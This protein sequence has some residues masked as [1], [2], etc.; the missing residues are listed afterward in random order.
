VLDMERVI[1]SVAYNLAFM[2]RCALEGINHKDPVFASNRIPI[3]FSPLTAVTDEG[4]L[5]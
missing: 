2:S 4:K 5:L 1:V 3:N